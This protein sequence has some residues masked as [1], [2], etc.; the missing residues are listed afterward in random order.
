MRYKITT[1]L[2]ACISFSA[3]QTASAADMPVKAPVYTP[4]MAA[5]YDFLRGPGYRAGAF[6]G[7]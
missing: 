5:G 7:Y 2:T 4:V 1:L 6:V 3:A